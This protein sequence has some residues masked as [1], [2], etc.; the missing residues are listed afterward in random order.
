MKLKKLDGRHAGYGV[1][2]YYIQQ[3]HGREGKNTFFQWREWCWSQ[4]GPGMEIWEYNHTELSADLASLA[5]GWCW[6]NDRGGWARIYFSTDEA[7]SAFVLQW[8]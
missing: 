5:S 3:N 4:F 6:V 7:A 8:Q 1:W 2:K